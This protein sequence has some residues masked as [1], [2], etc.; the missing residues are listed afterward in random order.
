MA[1]YA[2]FLVGGA[3]LIYAQHFGFTAQ[4]KFIFTPES[5]IFIVF[6]EF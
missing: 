6:I 5:C 1:F 2:S 3:A 4:L